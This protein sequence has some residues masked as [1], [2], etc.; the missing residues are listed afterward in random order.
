MILR[1]GWRAAALALA[2]AGCF[3]RYGLIRLRGPLGLPQRARWLQDA[4]R[5]VLSSLSIQY[6]VEGD[7]PREGLVVAN[8]L[9]YLDI[10]LL[11]AAMPCFFVAKAEVRRWPYFGRAACLGGTLFI[12][13]ASRASAEKVASAMAERLALPVPILLFP[14]GTSSD[15]STV[16][17]FHPRLFE[18]AV[19]ARVPITP[20]AIRYRLSNGAQERD[21]CWFGDEEFLPHL[22]KVLRAPEF[23]AELRFGAA[24]IYLDSRTAAEATHAEVAAMRTASLVSQ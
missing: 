15:G 17:R 21:L 5:P 14:E 9:S 22:W 2:L 23:T 12:D 1:V 11:S 19:L 13:R 16:M 6:R 7:A 10:A 8:H 24:K 3:L 4:C 18:P 20:A